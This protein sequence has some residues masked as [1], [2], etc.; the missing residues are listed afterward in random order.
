MFY[1]HFSQ[2]SHSKSHLPTYLD[3]SEEQKTVNADQIE[4]SA[5]QRVV[6]SIRRVQSDYALGHRI[7]G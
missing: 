1:I 7:F 4:R 5:H 2:K 6:S 3:G